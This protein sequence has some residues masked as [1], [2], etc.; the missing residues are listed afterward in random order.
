MHKSVKK[1]SLF[2][3]LGF[4][5]LLITSCN[6]IKTTLKVKEKSIQ[7]VKMQSFTSK[8]SYGY[9]TS[10][11]S[12]GNSNYLTID[13]VQWLTGNNAIIAYKADNKLAKVNNSDLPGGF[14]IRNNSIDSI[15]VAIPDSAVIIMQTLS[16]NNTGNYNFN[17]KITAQKFLKILEQK[18]SER[19]LHKLYNFKIINN[20]ALSIREKYIP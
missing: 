19:F 20:K 13:T 14:Y 12:K 17:Q 9:I 15:T 10:V 7:H 8:D 5:S 6:K 3:L 1:S 2:I 16:Y 11:Y 4:I 18:G